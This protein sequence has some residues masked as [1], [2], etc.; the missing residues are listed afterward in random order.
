[1]NAIQSMEMIFVM[2]TP[3][4]QTLM[5]P[6]LV[7]AIQDIKIPRRLQWDMSVK[8]SIFVALSHVITLI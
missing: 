3:L 2:M 8:V 1:M 7:N 6:I 4:A 5:V